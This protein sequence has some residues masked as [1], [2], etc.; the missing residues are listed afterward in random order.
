MTR[1]AG[2]LSQERAQMW[3]DQRA[4][5]DPAGSPGLVGPMTFLR[6]EEAL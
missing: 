5:W 4:S 6:T 1:L 3:T 2:V